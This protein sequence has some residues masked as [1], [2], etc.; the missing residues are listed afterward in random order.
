[1][2]LGASDRA[3]GL[4]GRFAAGFADSGASGLIEPRVA[5]MAQRVFESA[6]GG[7]CSRAGAI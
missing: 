1:L 4:V 7:A 3:I 6:L 5:T 2:L